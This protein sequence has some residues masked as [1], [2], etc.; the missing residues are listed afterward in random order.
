MLSARIGVTQ[1]LGD[2]IVDARIF[3]VD[4]DG[5]QVEIAA[6]Q[7]NYPL[8]ELGEPSDEFLALMRCISQWA[9]ST[10]FR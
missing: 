1:V 8:E 10:L 7:R 5:A 9:E 2:Y 4:D 3:S 6:Q